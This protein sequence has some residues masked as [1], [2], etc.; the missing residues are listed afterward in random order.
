MQ[1]VRN[2]RKWLPEHV[3]VE[4]LADRAF[5]YGELYELLGNY[6]WHYTIRFRDNIK[7]YEPGDD[8]LCLA[9]SGIARAIASGSVI[10]APARSPAAIPSGSFWRRAA[11]GARC[12]AR[13]CTSRMPVR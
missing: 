11:R 7:V 3:S 13:P 5:G 6:G 9:A 2:L 1:M 10:A 12:T 8:K 4:W